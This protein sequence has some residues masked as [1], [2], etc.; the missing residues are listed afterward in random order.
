MLGTAGACIASLC[1]PGVCSVQHG[2]VLY[3]GG[4]FT[5][6]MGVPDMCV[7]QLG[8]MGI[9]QTVAELCWFIC[10]KPVITISRE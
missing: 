7:I 6:V 4:R 10:C 5:G 1:V 2:H 3:G 8:I 9:Q